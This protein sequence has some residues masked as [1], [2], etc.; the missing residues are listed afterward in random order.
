MQVSRILPLPCSSL[1]YGIDRGVVQ[2]APGPSVNNGSNTGRGLPNPP[3]YSDPGA[4]MSGAG[5]SL[6][7]TGFDKGPT[8]FKRPKG[9]AALIRGQQ[10]NRVVWKPT[11][12]SLRAVCLKHVRIK[13][14][15]V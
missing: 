5:A 11:S 7:L 14:F 2:P 6:P 15:K 12:A 3:L 8:R 1:Y 9:K 13:S 10:K 4:G